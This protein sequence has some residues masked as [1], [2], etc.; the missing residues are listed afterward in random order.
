MKMRHPKMETE[1]TSYVCATYI[2]IKLHYQILLSKLL[3]F[4]WS[5]FAGYF[6]QAHWRASGTL[7]ETW[8]LMETRRWL[9]VAVQLCAVE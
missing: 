5:A 3:R 1:H 9:S 4:E 8:L 6:S 7:I 2:H